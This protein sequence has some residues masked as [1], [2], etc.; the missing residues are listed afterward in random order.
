MQV[1][2]F[3]V[4]DN[5]GYLVAPRGGTLPLDEIT[6]LGELHFGWSLDSDNAVPRLDWRSIAADIDARGYSIVAQEDVVGL[7][8][9]PQQELRACYPEFYLRRAA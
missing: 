2:V 1:N 4:G 8:G 9:R 5:E 7:L 6:A 3:V